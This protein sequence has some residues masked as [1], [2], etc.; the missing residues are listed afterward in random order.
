MLI[1]VIY[2]C[3]GQSGATVNAN[4]TSATETI[5]RHL[6]FCCE[7]EWEQQKKA[8]ESLKLNWNLYCRLL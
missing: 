4:S 5:V 3:S 6:L 8:I 1:E 7:C 2:L